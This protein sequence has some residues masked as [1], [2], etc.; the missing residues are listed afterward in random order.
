[1]G[2]KRN[3]KGI[4]QEDMDIITDKMMSPT[5]TK[6]NSYTMATNALNYKVT[7]KC[8]N[9]KQKEFV[10][11]IKD[12]KKEICFGVGSAG[13]G[14]TYLS[15]AAA[16]Q[17][18][19]D[20]ES[21]FKSIVI[22]IPCIESVTVLK[23][24]YLKGDLDD[25]TKCYKQNTYNN[26]I[27]ILESSGN[28]NPKE[29]VNNMVAQGLIQ[30]EFINFVKG[31]TFSNC[32][33]VLEEAEDYSK[34][35]ILLLLTRKGGN[36]CKMVISGDDKQTS[37]SDLKNKKQTTGLRFAA[38]ILKDMDE[39]AVTEFTVDDIVRDRLLTEIIKRFEENS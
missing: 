13:S 14:K 16:L 39:V 9:E 24:G 38:D 17:L 26:I 23:M 31:K 1:M 28:P 5:I 11:A 3:L 7:L 36:T 20:G 2:K 32:I 19:K 12:D 25:K 8:K 37:R 4:S 15:L 10:K 34:E 18:L 21:P 30:F 29:L 6:E 22:F 33:C 35:D 27:K